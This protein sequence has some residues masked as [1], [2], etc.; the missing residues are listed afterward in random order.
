MSLNKFRNPNKLFVM[1][2][3]LYNRTA[4]STLDTA[5]NKL[6]CFFL[7]FFLPL[8]IQ[9]QVVLPVVLT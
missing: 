9:I 3:S 4:S 8:R 1:V 6:K 7:L 5:G 2:F